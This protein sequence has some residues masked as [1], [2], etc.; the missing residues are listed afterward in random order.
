MELIRKS[1]FH[2]QGHSQYGTSAVRALESEDGWTSVDADADGLARDRDSAI[3]TIFF[4]FNVE[5]Y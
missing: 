4:Q 5:R 3:V 1:W 2:I